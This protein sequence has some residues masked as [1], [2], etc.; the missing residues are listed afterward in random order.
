MKPCWKHEL[1]IFVDE[2]IEHVYQW[3]VHERSTVRI[4]QLIER[5]QRHLNK[6]NF[7]DYGCYYLQLAQIVDHFLQ[8]ALDTR[9][10]LSWFCKYWETF[11]QENK[12]TLNHVIIEETENERT[13]KK[14]VLQR[15][16]QE[17]EHYCRSAIQCSYHM[18]H[19][20]PDRIK[21]YHLLYGES[22]VEW[23][24]PSL[25]IPS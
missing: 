12:L 25:H 9:P 22:F 19:S 1:Q 15:K 10:D 24:N 20:P 11:D 23:E 7:P 8:A 21:T 3:P 5:K 13:F 17:I 14:F 6:G 2:L 16:K 18:F 4:L